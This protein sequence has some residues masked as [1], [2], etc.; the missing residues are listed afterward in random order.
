MKL[1]KIIDRIALEWK[2]TGIGKPHEALQNRSGTSQELSR[3]RTQQAEWK[4]W[5][6]GFHYL[7]QQYCIHL[8]FF[9]SSLPSPQKRTQQLL[10][11]M[12]FHV[13]RF[14]CKFRVWRSLRTTAGKEI[15]VRNGNEVG[16]EIGSGFGL[17]WGI[18]G[19]KVLVGLTVAI[20]G[21]F[22]LMQLSIYVLIVIVGLL[23]R[24]R[25][26]NA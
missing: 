20:D 8:S 13:M 24:K 25:L 23:N 16:N 19:R 9:I 2:F 3:D 11:Q 7:C 14:P 18:W 22:L 21:Q 12:K 6:A 1:C 15:D 4:Y 5:F 26:L 10:I 17:W